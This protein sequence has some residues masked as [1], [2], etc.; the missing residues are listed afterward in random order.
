[1]KDTPLMFKADMVRAIWSGRKTMTRRP[2]RV[3]P[4]SVDEQTMKIIPFNGS[5]IFLQSQIKCPYGAP[6]DHLWVKETFAPCLE[7]ENKPNS[8]AGF[9]YRADWSVED[10]INVRDFPWQ[11]AMFM[12]KIAARIHL[13][14]LAVRVERLQ[15]I[16]EADAQAEGVSPIPGHGPAVYPSPH[17]H[18]GS[19]T[20]RQAFERLWMEINDPESWALNPWVWVVMFKKLG[21]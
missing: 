1:M 20:H 3:Q 8:K 19:G 10:D 6:G 4:E 21:G 11:S 5:A 2:L 14:I 9:T 7:K 16:S 13:E 17:A 18:R 12:P 15:D